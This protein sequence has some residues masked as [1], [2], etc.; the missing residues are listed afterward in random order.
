MTEAPDA[1]TILVVEDAEAIRKM[2]CAM[3]ASNGFRVLEAADGQE[4][5]RIAE[6]TR[7][8]FQLA[9]TD[10]VMPRMDGAEF[11]RHLNRLRPEVRIVFMSGYTDNP[12]VR[13]TEE[14]TVSFLAK[15]FTA[16]VLLETVRRTLNDPWQGL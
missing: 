5:L 16:D 9:L 1:E 3:L 6:D 11:A 8:C 7:H 14:S 12:M 2:V 13:R 10:M 15:P 4:A